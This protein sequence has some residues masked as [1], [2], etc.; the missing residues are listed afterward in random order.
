MEFDQIQ[1]QVEW[2]DEERRAEK[3]KISELG[4]RLTSLENNISPLSAQIKS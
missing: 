2:L 1:K 3:A 4:E